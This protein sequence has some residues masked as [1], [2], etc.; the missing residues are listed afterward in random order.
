MRVKLARS[1]DGRR[2]GAEA[3]LDERQSL[4]AGSRLVVIVHTLISVLTPR[5][6][7]VQLSNAARSPADRAGSELSQ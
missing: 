7:F 1:S 3:H 5:D 4:V 2:E 6:S